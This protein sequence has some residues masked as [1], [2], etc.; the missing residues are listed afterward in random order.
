MTHFERG[1]SEVTFSK[2]AILTDASEGI[3]H[4]EYHLCTGDAVHT[5][6]QYTVYR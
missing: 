4:K 2:V 5:S 6:G 1:Y 3:I